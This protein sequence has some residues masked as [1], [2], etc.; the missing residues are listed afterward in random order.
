MC[1]IVVSKNGKKLNKEEIEKATI[2]NPDGTGILYRENNDFKVLKFLNKE[3]FINFYFKKVKG[4][5]IIHFRKAT[6][7]KITEEFIHPF[8]IK[9]NEGRGF[10]FHNGV[11]TSFEKIEKEL[12]DVSDTYFISKI[13][14]KIYDIKK[15]VLFLKALDAGKFLI[16]LENGKIIKVNEFYKY[17]DFE[18]SNLILNSYEPSYKFNFYKNFN[19]FNY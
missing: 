14:S 12:N 6:S 3:D 18:V 10:L 5:H 1:L 19:F 7:G 13:V 9:T 8:E 11:W 4:F 15:I 17:K 2:F 16:V